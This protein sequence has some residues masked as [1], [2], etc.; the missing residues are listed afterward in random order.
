MSFDSLPVSINA[1]TYKRFRNLA[2]TL[3]D[4]VPIDP[5]PDAIIVQGGVGTGVSFAG[6]DSVEV[7][8]PAPQVAQI[9]P[10]SITF[11]LTNNSAG[12]V[13]GLWYD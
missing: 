10:F 3:S 2:L 11:L 4:T 12:T 6:T 13:I 9:F 8:F 7:G 1:K 5:P